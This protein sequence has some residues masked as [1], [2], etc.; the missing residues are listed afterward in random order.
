MPC[1]SSFSNNKNLNT[2]AVKKLLTRMGIE[3]C[4]TQWTLSMLRTRII[5]FYLRECH[6]IIAERKETRQVDAISVILNCSGLM[7][8]Y[9][10]DFFRL[11]KV[12][13]WAAR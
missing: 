7:V 13:I 6:L 10:D 5:Q 9:A 8:A 2:K 11:G 3:G 1:K 4:L 12:Y